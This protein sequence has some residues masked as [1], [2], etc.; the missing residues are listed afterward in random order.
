MR[1]NFAQTL[2][3]PK[4]L[5]LGL[6]TFL[7]LIGI[8]RDSRLDCCWDC[9]WDT[10]QSFM[11]LLAAVGLWMNKLW[12]LLIA[13]VASL[14]VAYMVGDQILWRFVR[15]AEIQE[16]LLHWAVLRA[17]LNHIIAARPEYFLT[18]LIAGI[19]IFYTLPSL[20]KSTIPGRFTERHNV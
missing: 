19:I 5:I 1:S 10:R 4:F 2:I 6:A 17:S 8:Y 13:A 9:S 14:W 18:V 12:S 7:F 16:S 11:L 20:W 15:L 3:Q